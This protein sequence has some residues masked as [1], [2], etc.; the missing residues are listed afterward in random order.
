MSDMKLIMERWDQF[1]EQNSNPLGLLLES[2]AE[3]LKDLKKNPKQVA[4]L[5]Q[6][7]TKER[8]K[9][10]LNQLAR[11]LLADPE[12]KAA[13]Q[14]IMKIP[15]EVEKQKEEVE[16]PSDL[17]EIEF[18]NKLGVS[19]IINTEEILNKPSVKKILPMAGPTLLLGALLASLA[20]ASNVASALSVTSGVVAGCT[21]GGPECISSIIDS[22]A[23]EVAGEAVPTGRAEQE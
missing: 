4:D 23:A 19:A 20:G 7:A 10:K 5:V 21:A 14:V 9:K 13:A 1:V 16:N 12:V 11:I 15:A 18:L 17:T 6:Q 8:D 3:A 2:R 22:V